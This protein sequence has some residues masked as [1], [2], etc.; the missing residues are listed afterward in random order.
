MPR[1]GLNV[2]VNGELVFK[3][4]ARVDRVRVLSGRGEIASVGIAE[5]DEVIDIVVERAGYLNP[6]S[7][8]VLEAEQ[9]KAREHTLRYEE[10]GLGHEHN[11]TFM[12]HIG[13]TPD[14]NLPMTP[15]EEE[16]REEERQ[17]E[18][19][20][21]EEEYPPENEAPDRNENDGGLNL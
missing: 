11:E 18:L 5:H 20:A 1:K 19:D 9:Q 13:E 16:E 8:D 7:A 4:E 21:H 2:R 6:R 14:E 10:E 15:E 12:N 17:A 3:E